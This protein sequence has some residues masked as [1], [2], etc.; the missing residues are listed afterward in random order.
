MLTEEQKEKIKAI[1]TESAEKSRQYKDAYNRAYYGGRFDGA[2]EILDLLGIEIKLD[3]LV[4]R[5]LRG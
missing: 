5:G 2:F 1:V 3:S 4:S